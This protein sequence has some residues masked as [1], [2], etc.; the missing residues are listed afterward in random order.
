MQLVLPSLIRP[1]MDAEAEYGFFNDTEWNLQGFNPSN[2]FR[3]SLVVYKYAQRRA[4]G[5]WKTDYLWLLFSLSVSWH[6]S[7]EKCN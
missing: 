3:N 2:V 6:S 1:A 4:I 7:C 5:K